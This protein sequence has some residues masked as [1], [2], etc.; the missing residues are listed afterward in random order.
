MLTS[1]TQVNTNSQTLKPSPLGTYQERNLASQSLL[2]VSRGPK[3]PI[4]PGRM[5]GGSI[6]DPK[7]YVSN[8]GL[9]FIEDIN[10]EVQ[11]TKARQEETLKMLEEAQVRSS[12]VHKKKRVFEEA[13]RIAK[14]D[15]AFAAFFAMGSAD[16]QNKQQ[17]LRGRFKP[18]IPSEHKMDS[19]NRTLSQ[20]GGKDSSMLD[21]TRDYFP[22]DSTGRVI[23]HRKPEAKPKKSRRDIVVEVISPSGVEHP[24]SPI[25][26]VSG[27]QG[28]LRGLMETKS[29]VETG[30]SSKLSK[31]PKLTGTE[32]VKFHTAIQSLYQVATD[33][34]GSPRSSTLGS[35]R[36]GTKRLVINRNRA[37]DL[38]PAQI[39]A[40]AIKNIESQSAR[41][42][43]DIQTQVAK[44]LSDMKDLL[45]KKNP[46][47]SSNCHKE[48]AQL[49]R[50]G[51][52][53]HLHAI[54][55][56]KYHRR[57][58]EER[59]LREEL[60]EEKVSATQLLCEAKMA[61]QQ[62][63]EIGDKIRHFAKG[64]LNTFMVR[65][66]IRNLS[67][68]DPEQTEASL[69]T[70]HSTTKRLKTLPPYMD[71]SESQTHRIFREENSGILSLPKVGV[72]EQSKVSDS[73]GSNTRIR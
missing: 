66:A 35:P 51:Q 10:Q 17:A 7:L 16:P 67:H 54:T 43:K 65:D 47:L 24:P 5:H 8:E 59:R 18:G 14:E 70:G 23:I 26:P 34:T 44:R 61:G 39:L 48:L 46:P 73:Q 42:G 13:T 41:Y 52:F 60:A 27:F 31:P 62:F 21:V 63:S 57:I 1:T 6:Y 30:E 2:P 71:N 32:R 53:L 45:S 12:V 37:V 28:L 19:S 64:S 25:Q 11:R 20:V 69:V 56:E 9:K 40:D 36:K 33:Y 55:E 58:E 38:P 29:V 50:I 72:N 22:G 4:Q 15:M 68:L 3:E 49:Q